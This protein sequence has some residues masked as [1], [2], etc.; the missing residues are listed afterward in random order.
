MTIDNKKIKYPYISNNLFYLNKK[1]SGRKI[2]KKIIQKYPSLFKGKKYKKLKD[3]YL[4][5][6]KDT[7]KNKKIKKNKKTNKKIVQK[8]GVSP[9]SSDGDIGTFVNDIIGLIYYTGESIVNGVD[10]VWN[11]VELPANLGTA[12]ESPVGTNE[13]SIAHSLI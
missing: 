4:N 5:N 6:N 8:G 9:P 3:K 10:L 2:T 13:P 12:Y 11:I 7:Y 1:S